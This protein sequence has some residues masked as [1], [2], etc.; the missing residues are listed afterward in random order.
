MRPFLKGLCFLVVVSCC[1]VLPEYSVS[2][3]SSDLI[4]IENVLVF[5]D[6]VSDGNGPF[7][8]W[9]L[10]NTLKGNMVDGKPMLNLLPFLNN[11]LMQD[12]P[13]Y[14][15]VSHLHWIRTRLLHIEKESLTA[16][17]DFTKHLPIPILPD[18][19]YYLKGMFTGGIEFKGVWPDYLHHMLGA[20]LDNRAMAG[21][22]TLCAPQKMEHPG[23]LIHIAH[24]VESLAEDFVSGS[25]VPPCE[26]LIISAW[27]QE[28]LSFDGSKT[29]VMFF[30]SAND[31]LNGWPD[32]KEVVNKYVSDITRLIRLGAR[33][34][35]VINLPDINLT[36]RY[37][38][39]PEPVRAWMANAV[40]ENNSELKAAL[41]AVRERYKETVII[42]LDA[43]TMMNQ[44][45]SGAAQHGIITD[46]P[47]LGITA[48]LPN[49][50][51]HKEKYGAGLVEHIMNNPSLADAAQVASHSAAG[52]EVPVCSNPDEHFFFDTVHPTAHTHYEIAQYACN[53]LNNHGVACS[54]NAHQP[55]I[56][57]PRPIV[58]WQ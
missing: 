34:V 9:K 45:I 35:V 20:S 26:G 49:I 56:T 44:L 48:G 50:D 13:G 7:S 41:Q 51:A 12:V 6:S 40:Q 14:A 25:L 38:L 5:G 2:D 32:S 24:G 43:A 55:L 16:L 57:A 30:N 33:H 31:Y 52:E 10:L 17:L 42:E 53:L 27:S 15:A 22:W 23:N 21:S 36:P 19:K 11:S 4:R 29:L 37:Q 39:A 28:N 3:D 8:T 1:S 46:K 47:C 18:P 54:T 58:S